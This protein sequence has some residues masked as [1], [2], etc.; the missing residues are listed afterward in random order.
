MLELA[1]NFTKSWLILILF[2][3]QTNWYFYIV[4]DSFE[5][6]HSTYLNFGIFLEI[7]NI[8]CLETLQISAFQNI[9][10]I[11]QN[12]SHSKCLCLK[13]LWVVVE[14]N[15]LHLS[16]QIYWKPHWHSTFWQIPPNAKVSKI[17]SNISNGNM[18]HLTWSLYWPKWPRHQRHFYAITF[19]RNSGN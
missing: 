15:P 10:N 6:C 18:I 7:W 9:L 8:K 11:Y 4:W 3:N 12:K 14:V 5:R 2:V 19:K 1:G 17:N 13:S 16:P